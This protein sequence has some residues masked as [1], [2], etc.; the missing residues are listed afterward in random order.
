MAGKTKSAS[1]LIAEA[2]GAVPSPADNPAPA[3]APAAAVVQLSPEA[4]RKAALKGKR[5]S[6]LDLQLEVERYNTFAIKIQDGV[7]PED[8]LEDPHFL[9]TLNA[10]IDKFS[11]LLIHDVVWRWEMRVRVIHKDATLNAFTLSPIGPVVWH[12]ATAPTIDWDEVKV[13]YAGDR[14]KYT[15]RFGKTTI[16]EGHETESAAY[17]YITRRKRGVAA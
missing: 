3:A 7:Q 5:P 6:A 1:E 16:S 12:E 11:E 17:E 13:V 4:Q 10:R 2:T 14:A 8:I 9:W 15:V